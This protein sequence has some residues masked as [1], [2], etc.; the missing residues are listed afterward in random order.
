VASVASTL[1]VLHIESC[2]TF[3]DCENVV[4]VRRSRKAA[5]NPTNLA[6]RITFED[7]LAYLLVP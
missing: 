4:S 7:E 2:S 1:Q 5:A 6:E 3:A